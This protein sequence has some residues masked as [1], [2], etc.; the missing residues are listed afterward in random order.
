MVRLV[1]LA[2]AQAANRAIVQQHIVIIALCADD[3]H[4]VADLR[5]RHRVIG[6][7]RRIAH[8]DALRAV[9]KVPFGIGIK[10]AKELHFLA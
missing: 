5:H 1:R 4:L 7:A 10:E 6:V 3:A 9:G 8:D 2:R